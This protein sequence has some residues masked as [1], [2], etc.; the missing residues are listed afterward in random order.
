MHEK[1]N[2]LSPS[3]ALTATNKTSAQTHQRAKPTT[4]LCTK[5]HTLLDLICDTTTELLVESAK[6]NRLGRYLSGSNKYNKHQ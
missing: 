5:T 6:L 1:A 4:R 3:T 2:A